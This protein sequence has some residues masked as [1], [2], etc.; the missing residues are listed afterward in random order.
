M[1][2]KTVFIDFYRPDSFSCMSLQNVQFKMAAWCN[3]IDFFV[4]SVVDVK[5]SHFSA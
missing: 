1:T 5:Q 4:R 2:R 3:I